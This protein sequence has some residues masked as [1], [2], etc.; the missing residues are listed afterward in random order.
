[1]RGRRGRAVRSAFAMVP[2]AVAGPRPEAD[3]PRLVV[4]TSNLWLG[5]AERARRVLR[6]AREHDVDVLSVQ[7]LRPKMRARGSSGAS[8][9]RTGSCCPTPARPEPGCSRS[10]R[11]RSA[12]G[13]AAARGGARGRRRAARADQGRPPAPAG[14]PRRRA[15]LARGDRGAA[16]LA[17]A[18]G[19]VQ[20]LAGDF[21]ATLD[22]AELRALLDRGYIDAADAAGEGWT[23]TWPARHQVATARCR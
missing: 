1:M 6:I 17:T 3:G 20:I 4:M 9:S 2:R 14:Q 22:H 7:E 19:D 23:P 11:S 5:R 12:G 15:R 8:S 18:R 13:G 10:G 21:N 16:R